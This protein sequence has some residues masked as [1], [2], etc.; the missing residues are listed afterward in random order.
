MTKHIT[1]E[2][3]RPEQDENPDSEKHEIGSGFEYG[4][5]F[6]AVKHFILLLSACILPLPPIHGLNNYIDDKP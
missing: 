4:R 6:L 2:L 3:I 1:M 5:N